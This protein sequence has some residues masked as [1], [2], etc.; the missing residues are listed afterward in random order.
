M[1]PFRIQGEGVLLVS[2]HPALVRTGCRVTL[3]DDLP[4]S[5]DFG[6]GEG[7]AVGVHEAGGTVA[8][9]DS[10]TGDGVCLRVL[11]VSI[12]IRVRGGAVATRQA[13]VHPGITEGLRVG[14]RV[15]IAV[16][17]SSSSGYS[18]SSAGS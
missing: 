18:S 11:M 9:A 10:V 8:Y 3:H 1:C 5:A 12:P 4:R 6:N 16:P 14:F 13:I 7:L 2:G 15:R 17:S